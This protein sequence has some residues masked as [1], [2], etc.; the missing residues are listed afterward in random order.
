MI[1]CNEDCSFA[2]SKDNE[3]LKWGQPFY[4]YGNSQPRV[5]FKEKNVLR[6]STGEYSTYILKQDNTLW[7]VKVNKGLWN[8]ILDLSSGILLYSFVVLLF[9]LI[10]LSGMG[11]IK[12]LKKRKK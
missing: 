9:L 4:L 2:I 1:Y 10:L 8:F 3:V 7:R 12:Q 5:L 6:I 11:L